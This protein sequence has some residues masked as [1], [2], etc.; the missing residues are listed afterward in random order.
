[1]FLMLAQARLQIPFISWCRREAKVTLMPYSSQS[2]V[3]ASDLQALPA[4]VCICWTSVMSKV[5]FG[6]NQM[7]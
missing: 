3:N 2:Y 5:G 6:L 4:S 7:A 1:M